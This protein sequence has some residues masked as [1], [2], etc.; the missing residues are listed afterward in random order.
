MEFRRLIGLGVGRWTFRQMRGLFILM[1]L[2]F[3][4]SRH[5]SAMHE[6]RLVYLLMRVHQI[7]RKRI[8]FVFFQIFP[9]IY[10]L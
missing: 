5:E 1:R 4:D 3:Q 10:L 6:N 7:W 8:P 2:L 9:I